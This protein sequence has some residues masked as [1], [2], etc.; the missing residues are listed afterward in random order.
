[1]CALA[2]V[3]EATGLATVSL[4][5]VLSQAQR[6]RPPRALYCE[7]PLGRPLG[8]PQD[9]DFQHAVLRAAFDLLNAPCDRVPVLARF[10]EE[11]PD[12]GEMPLS[13]PLPPRF[14]ASLHPAADEARGLVEAYERSR[15]AADGRTSFGKV[16]SVDTVPEALIAFALVADGRSWD[17]VGPVPD[18]VAAAT[19]VRS[20]YEEAAISLAEHTPAARQAEAWFFLETEA[21]KVLLGAQAAMKATKHEAW[22][23]IVPLNRGLPR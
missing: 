11:V 22:F 6:A 7:F 20:F 15:H 2:N 4:V 19:D 12:Q 23:F 8:R 1:V 3:F 10:P 13:C 18:P 9:P 5:H 17:D 21:A 14:D 16:L